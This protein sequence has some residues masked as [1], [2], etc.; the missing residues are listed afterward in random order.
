VLVA[1]QLYTV[2]DYDKLSGIG[3]PKDS[4]TSKDESEN[5]YSQVSDSTKYHSSEKLCFG[6]T[7]YLAIDSSLIPVGIVSKRGKALRLGVK[8][9]FFVR[10][11]TSNHKEVLINPEQVLYVR[12]AGRRRSV[13]VLA[14][15]SQLTLDQDT[16]SVELPFDEFFHGFVDAQSDSL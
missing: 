15:N 16:H 7:S 10:G 6:T 12:R 13:L 4:N 3:E 2:T 8:L 14:R 5:R 1:G 9:M 11:L